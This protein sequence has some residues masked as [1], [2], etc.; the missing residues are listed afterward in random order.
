MI[1][2]KIPHQKLFFFFLLGRFVLISGQINPDQNRF[3]PGRNVSQN[4]RCLF[5]IMHHSKAIQENLVIISLDAEKAFDKVE[6]HH[7]FTVLEKFHLGD[8]FINWVKILYKSPT[9]Q[10]LTDNTQSG[11]F[12]LQTGSRQGCPLSSLLFAL[13]IEPIAQYIQSDPSIHGFNTLKSGNKISLY[14]DDI[15]LYITNLY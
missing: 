1:M 14:A 13:T 12:S 15:L 8:E 10:V 9:A 3:S 4:T 2:C 11:P 5:N 6:C 7:L